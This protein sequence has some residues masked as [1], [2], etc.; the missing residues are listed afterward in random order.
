MAPM[1]GIEHF[2]WFGVGLLVLSG[3]TIS[4]LR[5][6]RVGIGVF[7]LWA[8]IRATAQLA[9]IALLLRGILAVPWTVVG[10]LVLMLTTATWTANRRLTE[11]WHGRRAALI[12]VA[13]GS[14]VALGLVFGLGLVPFGARY[15]V[16]T[17]GIVIGNSMTGSTLAGRNFLRSARTRSLEVE[18]WFAL[19]ATPAQAHAEIGREAVRESLLPTLDQTKSTGLVTLPGAFVGALFGGATPVEAA[20]FQLVV[21]ASVLL[22]M[23]ITGIVVTRIVGGTPYLAQQPVSS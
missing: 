21:L 13:L 10:F 23:A 4:L 22:A 14:S 9:V 17:A 2:V 3:V 16:A 12:G 15:L 7:P 19:G 5:W 11:L 6:Q 20:Q 18:S 8:L 1:A